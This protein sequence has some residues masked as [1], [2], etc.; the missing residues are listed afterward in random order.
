MSNP[1]ILLLSSSDKIYLG[2]TGTKSKQSKATQTKQATQSK[3][4]TPEL[5]GGIQ[6]FRPDRSIDRLNGRSI[7]R[8]NGGGMRVEWGWNGGGMGAKWGW[9]G[10]GIAGIASST[11]H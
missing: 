1:E 2:V 11:H 5:Q 9:N 6:I 4:Q 7:D 8:L 10:G 3:Q